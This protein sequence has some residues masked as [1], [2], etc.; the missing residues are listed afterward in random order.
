MIKLRLDQKMARLPSGR[1]LQNEA[2]PMMESRRYSLGK[3]VGWRGGWLLVAA[4]L[5]LFQTGPARADAVLANSAWP[6]YGHDAKHT[7]RSNL[8]GPSDGNLLAPTVLSDKITTQPTISPNGTIVVGV[9][10]A[11]FGVRPDGVALWRS[12]LGADAKFSSAV[13]D[14]NGFFYI[15][16]RDN[17]LWK[18]EVA[19]GLT[20]CSRYIPTDSDIRSSPTL[21]VK[22]PNR[23]YVTNGDE[24]VYAIRVSGTNQ[25][26]ID[27]QIRMDGSSMDSVSLADSVP[28]NGDSSGVLVV[29]G[30]R[31]I[32]LIDDLG[33]SGTIVAQRRIG[34]LLNGP[35]PL[36]HPQTGNIYMGSWD[37]KLYGMRPD[38]SDLFP[39][40]NLGSRIFSSAAL[41]PDGSTIYVPTDLGQL[42]AL[43]ALT[44]AERPGFPWNAPM[45]RTRFTKG[46]A[47]VVDALGHIFIGGRDKYVRALNPN[48]STLWEV[49][50]KRQ[51][52][53]P[54]VIVPGGLLVGSWDRRLYRFCPAP[55]GPP[56]ALQVCGYTVDTT[57]V[58]P[59]F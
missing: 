49:K 3:G 40:V 36:I 34:N 59:V 17:R 14:T 30:G 26:E 31:V 43:D 12:K 29:A 5:V 47:P 55:V 42:H 11:T 9:G 1:R 50:L 45:R 23:V 57:V 20:E 4:C 2:I 38:L 19:T 39:P 52:T 56:E 46:F 53:A 32:Y 16:A 21:S 27:W 44:G 48:G 35:S 41:S 15:G 24:N 13:F 51:V 8:V 18:K 28:G 54:A 6:M 22:F 58:P 33:Q 25:C 10:F 37:K 7:F